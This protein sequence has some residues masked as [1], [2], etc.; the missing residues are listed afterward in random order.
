MI[1]Q[2]NDPLTLAYAA[3]ARVKTQ[4]ELMQAVRLIRS[5]E[6]GRTPTFIAQCKLAA[7]VLMERRML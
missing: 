6:Q 3:G 7:E 5:L 4:E 2:A 1:P